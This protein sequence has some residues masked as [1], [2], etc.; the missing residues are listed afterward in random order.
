MDTSENKA[1]ELVAVTIIFVTISILSV[2]LRLYTRLRILKWIG[3]DDVFIFVA[4]G[5]AL[6]E[7]IGNLIGM[8][9][10]F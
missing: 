2:L 6:V 8:H 3:V 5:G 1:P 7:A 10:D 9:Q 4:A